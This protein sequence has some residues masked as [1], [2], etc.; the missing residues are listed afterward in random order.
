MTE[1]ARQR[2][3]KRERLQRDTKLDSRRGL[4]KSKLVQRFCFASHFPCR[5]CADVF[6]TIF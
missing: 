4:V 3:G 1:H 5:R 6:T 2:G